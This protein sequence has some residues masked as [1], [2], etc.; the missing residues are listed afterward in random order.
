[1]KQETRDS[2]GTPREDYITVTNSQE[3]QPSFT[4]NVTRVSKNFTSTDRV[5]YMLILMSLSFVMLNLPYVV[6]WVAFFIPFKQNLLLTNQIYFLYSFVNLSEIFH[7]A[8]FSIGYLFFLMSS[9]KERI[10]RNHINMT[11]FLKWCFF[12]NFFKTI[13]L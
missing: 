2:L 1:M 4:V 3:L 13:I 10:N 6:T 9:R 11:N 5:S 7:I 8:H 12:S